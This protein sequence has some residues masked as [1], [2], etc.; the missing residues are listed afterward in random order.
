[1]PTFLE[2][3]ENNEAILLMHLAG[4]LSQADRDEVEAML[5][6]DAGMRAALAELTALHAEVNAMISGTDSAT[7]LAGR[8]MAVGRVMRALKQQSE[9]DAASVTYAKPQPA[10]V[11]RIAWWVYPLAAAALFM[12]AMILWSGN[13]PIKLGPDNPN[14]GDG[15]FADGSAVVDQVLDEG[16][17]QITPRQDSLAGI[18]NDLAM[19]S[20]RNL[21]VPDYLRE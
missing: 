6:R 4:E 15:R 3:L 5:S 14:G 13:G 9:R 18:E 10:H 20:T 8:E 2:Q 12:V 1:M 21:E 11:L 16:L 19:L 17:D 7:A